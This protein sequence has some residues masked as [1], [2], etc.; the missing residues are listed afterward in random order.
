MNL[1]E[2]RRQLYRRLES[3]ERDYDNVDDYEEIL[4]IDSQI[5]ELVDE[6]SEIEERIEN[7]QL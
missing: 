3:L 7:E 1:S 5:E 2:R 4:A 6:I